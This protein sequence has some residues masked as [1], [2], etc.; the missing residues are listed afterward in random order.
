[1]TGRVLLMVVLAGW[2]ADTLARPDRDVEA[3]IEAYEAGELDAALDYFEAAID[4]HGDQPEL[5]YD[6]G[7]VLLAQGETDAARRAFERA[8]EAKDVEVRASAFYERGNVAFD[9]KEWDAAIEAV[10]REV[11]AG[12][13]PAAG[14]AWNQTPPLPYEAGLRS[15]QSAQIR[16]WGSPRS[17]VTDGV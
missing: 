11:S 10:A 7:L 1:M 16:G 8:S 2:L 9:N 17:S 14:T 3:G 15:R 4:R 6:R 13:P 12:L 5:S